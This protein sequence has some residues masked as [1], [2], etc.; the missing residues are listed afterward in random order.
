MSSAAGGRAGRRVPAPRS[1]RSPPRVAPLLV[2]GLIPFAL[3]V[4]LAGVDGGFGADTWGPAG[5]FL[6]AL[7]ALSLALAPPTRGDRT[8]LVEAALAAYA[9]FCL[10]SYASITWADVPA[11]AWDGANRTL[12]YGLVLALVSLRRWD[13]GSAEIALGIVAF[14]AAALAIG[15]LV[16]GPSSGDPARLFLGGRLAQ[17]I[18]Y[19]NGTANLWLLALWPALHFTIAGERSW[20]LRGGALA[21]A[22]TLVQTAV[23]SQSRGAAIALV[24][25][26]PLW[27]CLE[28]RRL[29]GLLS[30][31]SVGALTVL[32]SGPLLAVRRAATP[33]DI[34]PALSD[35]RLA[36]LLSALAAA[37]LGAGAP[38]VWRR[39]ASPSLDQARLTRL[40]NRAVVAVGVAAAIAGLAAIGSPGRWLDE[41]WQDFRTAGYTRV[42]AGE[43]RFEGSLGSGRYDFYRVALDRFRDHPLAGIGA[44]NFGAA[45]LAERRT[46]EA[47]R[48]PHSL[49]LRT[50][51]Q[52]GL[53]GTLLFLL[54]VAPLAFAAVRACRRAEAR[55]AG[56]AA[57]GLAGFGMWTTHGLVDWLWELPALGV[58]AL[59]LLCLAA[60]LDPAPPPPVPV[61]RPRAWVRGLLGATA[62]A[63]AVS[64]ALPGMAARLTQAAYDGH[65]RDPDTALAR[66]DRA[67]ELNVLSADPLVAKAVIAQRAGRREVAAGALRR[68]LQREPDN[69]FAH[70]ELGVLES[71]AGRPVTSLLHLVRAAGLNPRQRLI[72]AASRKVMSGRP[73][74]GLDLERRLN[75]PLRAKL[76]ATD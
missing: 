38:L 4:G 73:V 60:R 29:A 54:F 44:D 76:G 39:L 35:A 9:G 3:G 46:D 20:L 63:L 18:G 22:C 6:L 32:A 16:I 33:A 12:L 66:L 11:D 14:G 65:R 17:P 8:P 36:I 70:L 23:L 58:L 28:R 10:W 30:L 7:L 74:D 21:A 69:W 27:L 53:V 72:A 49:A 24:L 5:L 52:V 37:A 68:A 42:E 25:T 50:L 41:R 64:L 71:G 45:Y 13:A 61:P 15:V 1:R 34:G 19:V 67:A 62:L 31:A 2:P 57:A 55:A 40:G 48:Y 47:P 43:N 59:A 51:A 26:I 75:A 56:L